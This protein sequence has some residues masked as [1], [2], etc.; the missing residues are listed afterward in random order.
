MKREG[1][2]SSHSPSGQVTP[3]ILQ[4][5]DCTYYT[6]YEVSKIYIVCLKTFLIQALEK[7]KI[8]VASASKYEPPSKILIIMC[9]DVSE[10]LHVA[11]PRPSPAPNPALYTFLFVTP[12]YR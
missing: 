7:I 9:G 5:Q 12:F 3:I 11:G 1:L 2:G 8:H 4:K 10:T 6:Q